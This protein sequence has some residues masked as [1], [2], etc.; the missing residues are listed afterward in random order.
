MAKKSLGKMLDSVL[1]DV[2]Q[3]YERQ[4]DILGIDMDVVKEIDIDEISANPYQPRKHFDPE[5]LEE[6]SQSIKKHGLIQ[7]IIVIAKDNGFV[8]IAGERRLRAAK[9]A[10]LERIRAVIMEVGEQNMRELALIENIQRA[11]LNPIELA[12]S[13]KE[14]I[15]EHQITQEELA[16]I[17]HKS[18]AQITNTMRLLSL[19]KNT[20]RLIEEGR[21]TQGH[22]K[23]MVG[24]NASD[25]NVVV[26]TIL[27]QK[28]NVRD[29]EALIKKLKSNPS[30]KKSLNLIVDEK[31][32]KNL[33]LLK[34]K[35]N[36]LKINSK[37]KGKKIVLE[38][39]NS[40]IILTFLKKIS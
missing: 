11:D 12:N 38:F 16:G 35:L 28:L 13:Y 23:V 7:P 17:I 24:L 20:Q 26:D 22:A 39:E 25:E 34:D 5:A 37:L 30:E 27:G 32:S 19:S 29:T 4:F 8:L 21:L 40:D 15:N 2:E 31:Y 1:N 3:E 36:E 10:G 9:M 33:N 6:L 14:L 18:R